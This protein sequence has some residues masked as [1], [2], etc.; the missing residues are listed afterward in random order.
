[1][2]TK[3]IEEILCES[4]WKYASYPEELKNLDINTY[5]LKMFGDIYID[6][7]E[8]DINIDLDILKQIPFGKFYLPFFKKCR[9]I[10][11]KN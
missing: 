10:L 8:I 11:Y 9:L 6:T 2:K 4:N 5:W 3:H 7:Y 1:M